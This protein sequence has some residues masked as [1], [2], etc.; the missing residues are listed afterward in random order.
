MGHR[1]SWPMLRGTATGGLWLTAVVTFEQVEVTEI[2]F[3]PPKCV[4][5][6]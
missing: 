3:D 5:V 4:E 2:M 1:I 6:A